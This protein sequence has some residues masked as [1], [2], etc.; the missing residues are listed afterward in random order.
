MTRWITGL[1]LAAVL[2]APAQAG[3]LKLRADIFGDAVVDSKATYRERQ[4][5]Q[6]LERRFKVK[7][8]D[9]QPG[10]TFAVFIGNYSVGQMTANG[11]GIARIK[12]RTP[13]FIDDPSDGDPMPNN[14]PDIQAGDVITIGSMSGTFFIRNASQSDETQRTRLRGRSDGP[15]DAI[16]GR[17]R[18]LERFRNG[19]LL[20]KFKVDVEDGNPVTPCRTR[21]RPSW[22]AISS[23][24]DLSR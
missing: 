12:L 13:Q 23:P 17:A 1:L 3:W 16:D 21:S 7:V 2:T 22:R 18:Y 10:E 24:W 6:G 19:R 11:N 8:E 9:A 5:S 15:S 14:F 20:R 4:R